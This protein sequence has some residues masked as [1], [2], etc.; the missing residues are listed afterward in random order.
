MCRAQPEGLTWDINQVWIVV[1]Y[2]FRNS[3]AS[4]AVSA[5][6]R[7]LSKVLPGVE[8][9]NFKIVVGYSLNRQVH[10]STNRVA[11]FGF[12]FVS[13]TWVSSTKKIK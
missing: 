4:I 9:D 3:G 12:S 2:N 7:P 13:Q 6:A 1:N 8:A 11:P 5:V 10:V